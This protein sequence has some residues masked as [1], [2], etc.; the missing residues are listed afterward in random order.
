MAIAKFVY[1]HGFASSPRSSKAQYF[2]ERFGERGEALTLVDLNG[3]DFSGLTLTRQIQQVAA[4]L[5][6]APAEVVAIGSSLGGLT[7]AWLAEQS[8]QVVRVVLL[9]PA[10]GFLPRYLQQLGEEQVQQWRSSGSLPI[11]HYAEAKPLPLNYNFVRD[12]E[13]YD[14]RQLQRP[15]PTLIL[16]GKFDE[17]V[18]IEASRDYARSRP[19]VKLVELESNHSL[20]DALPL[21]WSETQA[22]LF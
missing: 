2:Q 20:T 13:Q 9:A 11:Y 8:V 1:L 6:P 21:L 17:T 18:P 14:D 16:H 4:L 12:A 5:P 10:F 19:W 3:G 7:A 22:F 15:T